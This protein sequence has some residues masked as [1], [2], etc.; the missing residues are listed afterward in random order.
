MNWLLFWAI[1]YVLILAVLTLRHVKTGDIE[2]Y[3]VNRR[4]TGTLLLV[5]TTLA[6]FVGGGTSMGLI[7]MGY[8]SGFAAVGIGVAYVIGFMILAFYAGKIHHEGV[9]HSLYSFPQ[10]L[11]RK[12]LTG[13][14]PHFDRSFTAVV[15]GVNIFIFFFLLAAQ[16]VGMAS[17]LKFVLSIDYATAAVISCLIVIAYTAFAGLSGVIITDALQFILILFMVAFIFIPGINHDTEGLRLLD[18]LPAEMLN[19]TYYGIAFLVALPLFIAPSVLVRMD[20][21][22]RV[23]AAKSDKT[24]RSMALWSG[25]GMLPFYIIFPLV[26]M[27]IRLKFGATEAPEDVAWLFLSRHCGEFA[28]GFAI[29]GIMSA[30]MSS[31]DSFLNVISISSIRDFSGWTK[32]HKTSQNK[33]YIYIRV[34]SIIFGLLALALALLLPEIVNLMV[35]GIGTIAIFVPITFLALTKGNVMRYRK[36]ALISVISGFICNLVFFILGMK[37]AGFFEPKSS[38]IPAFI[39]SLVTLVAGVLIVDHTRPELN[40]RK[41]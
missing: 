1:A 10:Y 40:K 4:K 3:L 32:K 13:N 9:K 17:I 26:G 2:D 23:L 21:W 19:G 37:H 39:I 7:A 8:E 31:G 16:F 30:L 35:V 15:T 33:Q 11:N 36:A 25:A 27:A 20:I 41:N 6:T 14:N 34:A 12:Y 18:K 24:A 22:Q 5:F 28:L 38:F 29:I